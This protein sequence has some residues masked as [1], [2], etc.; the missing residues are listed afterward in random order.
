MQ[1]SVDSGKDLGNL[2]AKI[3]NKPSFVYFPTKTFVGLLCTACDM[4]NV[5]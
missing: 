2:V 1:K 5:K 4:V 3:A